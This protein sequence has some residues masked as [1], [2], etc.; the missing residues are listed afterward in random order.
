[1]EER[2]VFNRKELETIAFLNQAMDI[3]L[4]EENLSEKES[5]KKI[6]LAAWTKPTRYLHGLGLPRRRLSIMVSK[7][8][9]FKRYVLKKDRSVLKVLL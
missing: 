7:L 3:N 8:G 5:M 2:V 9:G 4:A 6:L 1:M